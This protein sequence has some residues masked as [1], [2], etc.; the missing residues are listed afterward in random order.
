[1][2]ITDY[3]V[4]AFTW[5]AGAVAVLGVLC[6]LVFLAV[7]FLKIAVPAAQKQTLMLMRLSTAR[8][9]VKRME[10]EGL[11]V[12]RKDYRRLVAE[13]KP[14]SVEDFER[15]EQDDHKTQTKGTPT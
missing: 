5:L 6:F 1:V 14:Q 12:C 3:Y 11:T 10:K 4:I 8:Y 7:L 13:R 2:I 15:A 9:W